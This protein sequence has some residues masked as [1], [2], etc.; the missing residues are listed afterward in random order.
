[1]GLETRVAGVGLGEGGSLYLSCGTLWTQE[2][3]PVCKDAVHLLQALEVPLGG[4]RSWQAQ[5]VHSV[6]ELCSSGT[7]CARIE[8]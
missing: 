3:G 4:G 5:W 7:C 8:V 1:M 2:A 6:G